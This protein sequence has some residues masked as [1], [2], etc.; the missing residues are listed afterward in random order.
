MGDRCRSLPLFWVRRRACRGSLF[1]RCAAPLAATLTRIA[2]VRFRALGVFRVAM[3]LA[4][5]SC[6]ARDSLVRT[7]LGT[8]V[9]RPSRSRLRIRSLF[10]F[11]RSVSCPTTRG[12][13]DLFPES[14]KK[15]VFRRGS[16]PLRDAS[17]RGFDSCVVHKAVDKLEGMG[18]LK[19]IENATRRDGGRRR[20]EIARRSRRREDR[21]DR[22]DRNEIVLFFVIFASLR[23]LRN[24]SSPS[25]SASPRCI[26]TPF[27]PLP[28]RS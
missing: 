26:R 13:Y 19:I 1:P 7:V 18:F 22:K 14:P 12:I 20:R 3:S 10:Q 16:Y 9:G 4:A 24:F 6:R 23:A 11:R 25:S 28:A 8:L 21:E 2:R 5:D 27:V 17:S 15:N